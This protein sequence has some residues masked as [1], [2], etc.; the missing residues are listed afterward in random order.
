MNK[1]IVC[2][3]VTLC[4][5]LLMLPMQAFAADPLP[6]V[7]IDVTMANTENDDY[8]VMD[9]AINLRKNDVVYE[10]TGETNRKIQIW[11]SNSPDPAKTFYIRLNNAA[12]NKGISII[13]SN[14]AKLVIEVVDGTTN[15][16][17]S[18]YAVDLTIT[19]KGTINSASIG[20]TQQS[21]TDTR[22]T[23]ALYIKDTKIN[24]ATTGN[25]DQWNGNCVLDGDA[26]VTYTMEKEYSALNLGQ[27]YSIVT[28]LTM[29]GNSKLHCLHPNADE[30]S[31]YAV[32]GLSGYN[33]TIKLQDN[34]YL[35]AQ[36]RAGSGEYI[37]SGIVSDGDIIVEG[38]A[39]IKATSQ[40]PAISTWGS[41]KTD[42][43]NLDLNSTGSNAIYAANE[44]AIKNAK[45]EVKG[46]YPA[47]WSERNLLVENS[48]L[49]ATSI[50]DV[51]LY[52]NNGT[53]TVKDSV[54]KANSNIEDE[55]YGIYSN[56]GVTVSGSWIET[57][58]NESFDVEPHSIKD[59]VL[60][61]RNN[62]KVIGNATLP[63]DATVMD[64]MTLD[65]PEGTSLIV[66]EGKTFTNNGTIHVKGEIG[67]QGKIICNSHI[68]GKL[69]CTEQAVCDVCLAKYGTP[70]GHVW[71]E[72]EYTWSEDNATITAKRVCENDEDHVETETVETTSTVTQE[73]SCT[74]DE[75]TTFT[76]TFTNQAFTEQVKEN[77]VTA[78]KQGHDFT[79]QQHDETHHWNKCTRCDE[80][81]GYAEHTGGEGTCTSKA[82]C[83]VCG[84]VYGELDPANHSGLEH[85]AAKA[86]TKKAE[87][88]IEYWHCNDCGKYFADEA[89]TKE[90]TEKDTVTAKLKDDG[91]DG[92]DDKKPKTGDNNNMMLWLTLLLVSG[93]VVIAT[94]V[95]NKK[96]KYN[97]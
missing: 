88:N 43:G 66:P 62:G 72:P 64:K 36:G 83:E 55:Y 45:G 29:K 16:V 42:G 86:A 76:A 61:N 57:T 71:S 4:M 80:I 38:N 35:E 10:L 90:I 31:N 89:A 12:L 30:P 68:G 24:V 17:D 92:K 39:T 48:D 97:R 7:K 8:K 79:E 93:G 22:L 69:T 73:K 20:V 54:V 65:I 9:N 58:G 50:S 85:V 34:A 59:S 5:I 56:N 49:T 37:G 81:D 70:S 96:R 95:V 3:L 60:F 14:G 82:I 11:G 84:A 74:L 51:A 23:S 1:R 91:K 63:A 44:I 46:Y 6:E 18:A 75:L 52:S 2:V 53:I 15:Y 25:S 32:D 33:G 67:R 21:K 28:T 78:E 26:D 47:I 19:G 94:I 41:V 40:G 13:N 77:V 27:S 87:G